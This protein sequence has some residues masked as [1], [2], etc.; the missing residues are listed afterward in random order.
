MWLV[1]KVI[2][3]AALFPKHLNLNGDHGNLLVLQKRLQWRGVPAEV[4]AVTDTKNL[5]KYDLVLA[6]HG[7]RAAWDQVLRVDKMFVS[8]LAAYIE[9]GKPA[10]VT[11]SAY[12][13][14]SE[15]LLGKKN[16]V[17][18]HRSLFVKTSEGVVG[19]VN[20]ASS[21]NEMQW[22]KNALLTLLHGPLLAK[23]PEL[24]DDLIQ[25]MAIELKYYANEFAVIEKLAEASRRIAFEN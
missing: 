18:E 8:N 25:R 20:S 3:L 5:E 6:G 9:S 1:S 24:A 4:V 22:H 19:Y 14:V 16:D 13:L 15:Q 17:L 2:K 11:A 23:N 21:A 12:D 10:I 7:S